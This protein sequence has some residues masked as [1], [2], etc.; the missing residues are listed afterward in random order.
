MVTG[1]IPLGKLLAGPPALGVEGGGHREAGGHARA[2]AA[3]PERPVRGDRPRRGDGGRRHSVGRGQR[4]AI[5]G[6]APG[7]GAQGRVQAVGGAHPGWAA[8]DARGESQEALN[9]VPRSAERSHSVRG[10]CGSWEDAEPD[11]ARRPGEIIAGLALVPWRV[12]TQCGR[13]AELGDR[14]CIWSELLHTKAEARSGEAAEQSVLGNHVSACVAKPPNW[15]TGSV[16][17]ARFYIRK[18]KPG[19][20]RLPSRARSGTML[21]S[22][23]RS[24]RTVRWWT[25]AVRRGRTLRAYGPAQAARIDR[26]TSPLPS[27]SPRGQP[28]S[29][30]S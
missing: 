19:R 6:A 9:G 26:C 20:A 1:K 25:E 18:R 12:V 15:A 3:H 17:G 14:F 21:R 7:R 11:R 27:A 24:A 23:Q 13:G 8:G 5:E 30:R 28:F 2:D 22:R 29:S 4:L 10:D 16:S